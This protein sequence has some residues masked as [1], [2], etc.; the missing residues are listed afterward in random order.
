MRVA[1]KQSLEVGGIN[2]LELVH[3]DDQRDA[4]ITEIRASI[5]SRHSRSGLTL[6]K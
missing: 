5:H 4:Q 6:I 1:L 2:L 3:G